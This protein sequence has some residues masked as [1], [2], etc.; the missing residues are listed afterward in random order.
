MLRRL[1][2]LV[3]ALAL[4]VAFAPASAGDFAGRKQSLDA[5]IANLHD[6]LAREHEREQALGSRLADVNGRIRAL[7]G[8]VG[9]VST[10]L[11]ALEDDLALHQRKLDRLKE[12]FRLQ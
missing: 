6:K 5:R 10:R 4:L 9:G 3:V 8:R 2:P 7:E 12:L 1:A 11:T